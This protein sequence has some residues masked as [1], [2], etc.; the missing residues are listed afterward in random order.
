[1]VNILADKLEQVV[2]VESPEIAPEEA[3]TIQQAKV[4]APEDHYNIRFTMENWKMLSEISQEK[5]L[6]EKMRSTTSS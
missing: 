3:Q 2:G 6:R 5:K 4:I 1:M